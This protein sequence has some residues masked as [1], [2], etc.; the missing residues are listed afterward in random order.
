MLHG[1]S[2]KKSDEMLFIFSGVARFY[3]DRGELLE[4][5]PGTEI[6]NF[7]QRNNSLNIL[8]L[9]SIIQKV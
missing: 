5:S 1:K 8:L 3:G 4:W 9:E 2:D 6:V 7:R